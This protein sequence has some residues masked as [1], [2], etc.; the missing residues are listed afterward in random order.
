[1]TSCL[2][3]E[4]YCIEFESFLPR[5]NVEHIK[6]IPEAFRLQELDGMTDVYFS[7]MFTCIYLMKLPWIFGQKTSSLLSQE[8]VFPL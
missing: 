4:A 7:S 2:V 8:F 1:M 6:N 3:K 5:M